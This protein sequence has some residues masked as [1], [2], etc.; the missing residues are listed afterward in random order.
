MC[1]VAT[2][3]APTAQNY[4]G[5]N[6]HELRLMLGLR[7]TL[8]AACDGGRQI[9]ALPAGSRANALCRSHGMPAGC[10]L[11]SGSASPAHGQ[12]GSIPSS[13]SV[14]TTGGRSDI[15]TDAHA[16]VPHAR[17]TAAGSCGGSPGTA[18]RNTQEPLPSVHRERRMRRRHSRP[19]TRGGGSPHSPPGQLPRHGARLATRNAPPRCC[20]ARNRPCAAH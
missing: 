16:W 7:A 18:A 10:S 20:K 15:S 6:E 4:G 9:H 3:L 5:T 13:P 19:S 12:P 11:P 1:V 2:S 14:H 8:L 17:T